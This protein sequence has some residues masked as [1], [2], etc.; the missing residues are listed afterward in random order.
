MD[1]PRI[2]NIID[3]AHRIHNPIGPE[4]LAS[5]GAALH[6]ESVTRVLSL[7]S[8]SGEMLADQDGWDRY[9]AAK[10]LT[11]RR[12]LEVNPDDEFAKD[13]RAQTDPGTRA[14][15]RLHS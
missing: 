12:W 15:R 2:F 10:W 14:L 4:K 9:E 6:L 3:S 1:I 13:V 8:G 5:L 7:R 11:I